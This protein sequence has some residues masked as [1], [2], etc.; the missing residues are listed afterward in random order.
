MPPSTS[1]SAS[2]SPSFFFHVVLDLDVVGAGFRADT[3]TTTTT[4][5]TIKTTASNSRR[6][7][8]PGGATKGIL[9]SGEGGEEEEE[10]EGVKESVGAVRKLAARGVGDTS[11]RQKSEIVDAPEGFTQQSVDVPRTSSSLSLR[12]EPPPPPPSLPLPHDWRYGQISNLT[13][14]MAQVTGERERERGRGPNGVETPDNSGHINNGI[15]AAGLGGLA[16]KGK[17]EPC[18]PTQEAVGWGVVRLYRDA[19][20]T[21][22]LYDEPVVSAR[23]HKHGKGVGGGGGGGGGKGNTDENVEF[24]DE[25]CTTLCILAVPSYLTP[26]DFLGF[27]G[28]KTRDEVS[29]F[30]MIRTE[31]SNRYMVLMRF[32]NGKKARQWRREWNGKAFDGMEVSLFLPIPFSKTPT[33]FY[34]S[35]LLMMV[36]SLDIARELSRRLCQIHLVSP[37]SQPVW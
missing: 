11:R 28:E 4:D 2:S 1:T 24:Q 37:P 30:R 9:V 5:P 33:L 32:R 27:V 17:Y 12:S 29:H 6:E 22:G 8:K 18:D 7:R 36:D 25:D 14:A 23:H 13:I 16:T 31:R 19:G 10:G 21:P 35:K 3:A 34:I 15:S 26:S 20:E